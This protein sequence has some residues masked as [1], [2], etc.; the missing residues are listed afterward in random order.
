MDPE[1]SIE[2]E[3]EKPMESI[4]QNENRQKNVMQRNEEN[5]GCGKGIKRELEKVNAI[6]TTKNDAVFSKMS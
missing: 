2:K 4:Y 1:V 3:F 6:Q 5:E